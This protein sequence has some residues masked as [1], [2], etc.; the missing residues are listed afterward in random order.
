MM[1]PVKRSEASAGLGGKIGK[2]S[3]SIRVNKTYVQHHYN[4]YIYNM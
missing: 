1:K 4:M 2:S 3:W